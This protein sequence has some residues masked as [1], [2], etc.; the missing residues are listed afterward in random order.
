MSD[1]ARDLAIVGGYSG[2]AAPL[3]VAGAELPAAYYA[4][5]LASGAALGLLVGK[6]LERRRDPPWL[7]AVVGVL[8]GAL[9]G[10]LTGV[11]G[12][13]AVVDSPHRLFWISV[14]VAGVAGALQLGWLLVPIQAFARWQ[15][16]RWPLLVAACAASH[17]L[18]YAALVILKL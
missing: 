10:G 11:A 18:G 3:T 7:A 4:A 16:P 6:L 12:G 14:I 1:L 8:V 15:L 13:F 9:W 5:T 2:L 17:G